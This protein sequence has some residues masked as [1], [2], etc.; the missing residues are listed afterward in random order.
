ML[1]LGL[2]GDTQGR[3]RVDRLLRFV[4]ERFAAV[5]EIWHVGD[6]QEE[7]VLDGLRAL[8]KPLTVVNGNAPDDPR[9]PMQVRRRLEGLE[10]GMVHRPPRKGDRWA[11]E[12]DI[13]IHGHT[14]R[15]RDEQVGRTRFINVSTPTAAG[16]SRERTMGILTLDSGSADLERVLVQLPT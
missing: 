7:A 11:S 1:R 10:V 2:I 9:H 4:T 5:D 16:F 12:L 13:C 6:W 15:W 14:H 3:Y 8:D